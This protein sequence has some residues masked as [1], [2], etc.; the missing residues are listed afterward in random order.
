MRGTSHTKLKRFL[1][2]V[3]HHDFFL[4]LRH[5]ARRFAPDIIALPL[6]RRGDASEQDRISRWHSLGPVCGADVGG[7]RVSPECCP[8]V[9]SQ[10]CG[11]MRVLILIFGA[12][13]WS[14]G[15]GGVRADRGEYNF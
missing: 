1:Q 6:C 11:N 5:K 10:G 9:G 12:G 15:R 14:D 8:I 3:C 4:K 13:A 7:M 2:N